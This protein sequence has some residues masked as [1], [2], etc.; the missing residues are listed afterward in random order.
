MP[1]RM[2]P[3]SARM[4]DSYD[5]CYRW[6]PPED[7]AP[8]GPAASGAGETNCSTHIPPIDARQVERRAQECMPS[9]LRP[10]HVGPLAERDLTCPKDQ[11]PRDSAV[12]AG[13]QLDVEDPAGPK[14]SR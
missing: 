6:E 12:Q 14:R 9:Q 8:R 10:C 3:L 7:R 2:K 5:K 1:F 13:Q 11:S 4:P